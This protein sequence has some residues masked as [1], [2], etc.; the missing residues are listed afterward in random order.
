MGAVVAAVEAVFEGG[1]AEGRQA[2]DWVRRWAR[3]CLSRSWS[4]M[5]AR[6]WR[7]SRGI[8]SEAHRGRLL[9]FDL[10]AAAGGVF[11]GLLG[12]VVETVAC[13]T[14]SEG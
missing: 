2:V 10:D 13:E 7:A 4:G 6:R 1:G 5:R 12:L 14:A 8:E 9:E 3:Y 11:D